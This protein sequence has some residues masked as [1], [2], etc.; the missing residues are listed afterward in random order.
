MEY[1]T[2]IRQAWTIT[3]RNRFLWILGVLAGG[4]VGMPTLTW[5]SSGPPPAMTTYQP[6]DASV[7][8]FADRVSAW[9]VENIALLISISAAIAG[10]VLVLIVVSFIAQGAWPERRR[11]S[12]AAN[13]ARW[14]P[15]GARECTSSG[16]MLDC[17]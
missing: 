9:V 11:T 15:P 6:G 16:A 10:L 3:W 13:Q 12:P 4:A 5:T 8:A 1:G 14:G 2:V 7:V 17:G